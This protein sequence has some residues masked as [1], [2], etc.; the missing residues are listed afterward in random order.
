MK[1][2][3]IIAYYFPPSGGA[4]VQRI[5][6]FVKYL[7]LFGWEPIVLTVNEE[8]DFPIRDYSLSL[9]V[10]EN[11]KVIRTKIFEPY[12]LYRRF[13]GKKSGEATDIIRTTEPDHQ[14]LKTRFI[15]WVRATFFIPDARCYWPQHAVKAGLKL[16]QEE[17]IDLIFSSSS[18]NTCHL[19]GRELKRRTGLPWVADFRDAWIWLS[20]PKRWWV[21]KLIDTKME[22]SVLL[23][24]DRVV[25]STFGVGQDLMG[26]I[27]EADL[28]PA[29]FSIITN[30]WD[31]DDFKDRDESIK[32]DKFVITHTGAL[33]DKRS[34]VNILEAAESLFIKHPEIRKDFLF[35]FVGRT[36]PRYM[37]CFS[38][39]EDC[40]ELIPY[41]PHKKSVQ[42]LLISD[43]L[44]LLIDTAGVSKN[45]LTGKIFEYF[46]ADRPV[47]ALAPEGD[48][49]DLLSK[50]EA[51]T[52]VDPSD[53]QAIEGALYSLYGKWKDNSLADNKKAGFARS[54][55]RKQLTK[56][57][58][59]IFEMILPQQV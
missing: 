54:F 32:S 48:A 5:L 25:A 8:A 12:Q 16:I 42:Y 28:N 9:E 35:R 20:T 18:P 47:L 44:L 19:I 15:E 24:A 34:P 6:K 45:I 29:K 2:V 22:Q 41:V 27:N 57:L 23:E 11:V 26:R 38:R 49:A 21:P 33:Y 52:I 36:D 55:E 56:L 40:V 50:G 53:L 39:F 3:L 37:A 14:T 46:G 59:E 1:K 58:A 51:G 4:G 31:E 30:G 10:A 17:K 13:T 43:V 7:P